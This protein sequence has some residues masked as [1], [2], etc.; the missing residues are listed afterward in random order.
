MRSFF[1][2]Q[3]PQGVSGSPG[4]MVSVRGGAGARPSVAAEWRPLRSQRERYR[5]TGRGRIISLTVMI[6][7]TEV[8]AESA[9]VPKHK[10]H[11]HVH[12]I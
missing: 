10:S 3:N 4:G 8:T 2:V 7:I 12:F 6:A 11:S 9:I 1:L 5:D